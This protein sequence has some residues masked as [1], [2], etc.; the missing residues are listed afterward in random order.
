MGK[1]IF[2][3]IK[4]GDQIPSLTKEPI[5]QLQLIKYAGA[6]GD[7]NQIHTVPEYAKEAGLDGTIAH[8]MLVMG[9]I[10]QM[11]SNWA[12]VKPVKEFSVS[13]KAISRPGDVLTAKGEVKRKVED[14]NGK[15]LNCKVQIEDQKGEVKVG[16]KFTVK[17]D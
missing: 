11:I 5:T 13:F 7:F 10:G 16:G 4:E 14:A 1:L 3:D 6:S 9:M 15:F 12:G 2:S 8:G 17:V